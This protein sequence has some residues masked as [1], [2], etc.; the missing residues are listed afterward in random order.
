MLT[1]TLNLNFVFFFLL[2][3]EFQGDQ[4]DLS[5]GYVLCALEYVMVWI[6][7]AS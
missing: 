1:R 3:L 2:E 4:N 6:L 7:Y 5:F